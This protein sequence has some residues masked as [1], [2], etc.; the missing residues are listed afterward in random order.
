M[1]TLFR[2]AMLVYRVCSYLPLQNQ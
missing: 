2:S 1:M